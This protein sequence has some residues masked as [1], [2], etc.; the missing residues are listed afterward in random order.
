LAEGLKDDTSAAELARKLDVPTNRATTGDTAVRLAEGSLAI[1]ERL[2]ALD[3]SNV[4]WQKDVEV[5]RRLVARLRGQ[6]AGGA[7]YVERV[8]GSERYRHAVSRTRYGR[9]R[10]RLRLSYTRA[11]IA[12]FS[13]PLR[14]FSSARVSI[15][16]L[17]IISGA[18]PRTAERLVL[19]WAHIHQTELM[20]NWLLCERRAN[21]AKIDPLP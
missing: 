11:A 2:A 5:S 17:Q 18:L 3:L 10:F 1:D 9:L 20:Q 19:E 4:K 8:S 6:A 7:S 16:D 21:P 13:C 14:G 12:E 15:Q